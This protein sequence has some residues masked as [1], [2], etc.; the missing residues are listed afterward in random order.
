M[1]TVLSLTAIL[2]FPSG[3]FLLASGLLF[4]WAD[5]KLVAR[6]Q[7][8]VGPRWFQPLADTLKLL[9]KGEIV[10]DGVDAT[11]FIGLILVV[12]LLVGAL[13]MMGVV[14]GSGQEVQGQQ[15]EQELGDASRARLAALLDGVLTALEENA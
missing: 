1:N 14:A 10:P 15:I 11:L 12:G 4:E 3:L 8:R 7:N 13:W 6:F 9:A 2:F 5:R